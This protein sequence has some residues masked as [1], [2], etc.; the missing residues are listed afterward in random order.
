RTK[1]TVTPYHNEYAM[2]CCCWSK[3]SWSPALTVSRVITSFMQ[4]TNATN[5]SWSASH[6]FFGA[7][8]CVCDF[9][10]TV[11]LKT[12][13]KLVAWIERFGQ[14]CKPQNT[15]HPLTPFGI[16]GFG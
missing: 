11:S 2:Y 14:N 16:R 15:P 6:D 9:P 13:D 8:W 10:P 12:R 3:D 4:G 7:N 5:H 1:Q